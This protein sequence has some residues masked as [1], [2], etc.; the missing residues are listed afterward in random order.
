MLRYEIRKLNL[1]SHLM[2][3]LGYKSLNEPS[4][5]RSSLYLQVRIVV[6]VQGL[7][8]LEASYLLGYEGEQVF[9]DRQVSQLRQL[10]EK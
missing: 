1:L 10:T 4:S 6:D 3:Q 2:R 9:A 8:I 5:Y 7:E